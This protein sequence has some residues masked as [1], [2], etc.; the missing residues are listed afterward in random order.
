MPIQ[1]IPLNIAGI[2][3]TNNFQYDNFD[4]VGAYVQQNDLDAIAAQH[5]FVRVPGVCSTVDPN[6][7]EPLSDEYRGPTSAG[8]AF[9]T[10]AAAAGFATLP[11][12]VPDRVLTFTGS[13]PGAH[14][15]PATPLVAG[16]V[17]ELW[18]H[19]IGQPVSSGVLVY[20]RDHTGEYQPAGVAIDAGMAYAT[21]V[22]TQAGVADRLLTQQY[23]IDGVTF[24]P[25]ETEFQLNS[26]GLAAGA[27]M[28]VVIYLATHAPVANVAGWA[29]VIAE[30]SSTD[31]DVDDL[32]H[33][34]EAAAVYRTVNSDPTTL[35]ADQLLTQATAHMGDLLLA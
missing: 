8:T 3:E 30:L 22:K 14:I 31:P 27:V 20:R 10:Q 33:M 26:S 16:E 15:N 23:V 17:M 21:K 35:S 28:E 29:P 19:E 32:Q 1:E 34:T 6:T 2:Q 5:N 12:G 18:A 11:K 7:G 25:I 4:V 24:N 9:R 13:G